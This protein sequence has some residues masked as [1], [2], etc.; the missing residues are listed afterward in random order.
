MKS[1]SCP[2]LS[3]CMPYLHC[4]HQSSS[5]C[6]KRACLFLK[7]TWSY[8]TTYLP[9]S[10]RLLPSYCHH[11]Y[12]PCFAEQIPDCLHIALPTDHSCLLILPLH[13]PMS[14]NVII[15][16]RPTI[17]VRL[18]HI[19]ALAHCK[20]CYL[21]LLCTHYQCRL[22]RSTNLLLSSFDALKSYPHIVFPCCLSQDTDELVLGE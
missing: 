8:E 11:L 13:M 21:M 10:M 2:L 20:Q 9:L 17:S 1:T 7:K 12:L 14:I 3:I 22:S 6:L 15:D 5:L 4:L 18:H 19:H 16:I